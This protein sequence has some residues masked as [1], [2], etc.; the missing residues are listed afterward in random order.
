MTPQEIIDELNRLPGEIYATDMDL[1]QSKAHLAELKDSLELEELNAELGVILPEKS[2]VDKRKELKEEAVAK[3]PD[4]RSVQRQIIAEH[5]RQSEREAM[6]SK[7]LR[8]FQATMAITE[9]SAA[10]LNVLA[11]RIERGLTTNGH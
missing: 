9:L 10:Q 11:A 8:Q 4:V 3:S 1:A 2:T 6:R 7:S 5:I